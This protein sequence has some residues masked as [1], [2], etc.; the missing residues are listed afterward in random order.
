MNSTLFYSIKIACDFLKALERL[1]NTA[2]A[3][4]KSFD[5]LKEEAKKLA[6]STELTQVQSINEIIKDVFDE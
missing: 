2:M 6:V 3:N 1:E 5:E 4:N